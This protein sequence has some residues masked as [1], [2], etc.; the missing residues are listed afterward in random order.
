MLNIK[1][2][3]HFLVIL[4]IF[5]EMIS[6]DEEDEKDVNIL[7]SEDDISRQQSSVNLETL[8]TESQ[9][10]LNDTQTCE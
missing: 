7:D 4:D 3:E 10:G 6:S 2:I 5:G 8:G 9:E 1:R